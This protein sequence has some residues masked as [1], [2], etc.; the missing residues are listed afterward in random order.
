MP[1]A[2]SGPVFHPEHRHRQKAGQMRAENLHP[3]ASR[4]DQRRRR[5]GRKSLNLQNAP[6]V[7]CDNR[8][9]R[10]ASGHQTDARFRETFPPVCACISR[11]SGLSPEVTCCAAS[12]S[13][14]QSLP[15]STEAVRSRFFISFQLL[16][17]DRAKRL[18]LNSGRISYQGRGRDGSAVLHIHFR[19]TRVL[20]HRTKA[21]V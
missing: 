13:E 12:A 10:H 19:D 7:G 8:P 3:A 6:D 5:S 1:Q 11:T 21:G 18:N 2:G 15:S 16:S 17:C 4:K 20:Y 14:R 9:E